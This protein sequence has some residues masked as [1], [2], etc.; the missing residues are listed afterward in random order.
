MGNPGPRIILA[1][2][3]PQRRSILS[4]L[5]IDFDVVSPDIDET[6]PEDLDTPDI[7]E[8]LARKKAFSV[9]AS[10]PSPA[11]GSSLVIA[12]DTL[13]LLGNRVYG[14]PADREEARRFL[15]DLGGKTH[16]V[17][18]GVAI[19]GPERNRIASCSESAYVTVDTINDLDAYL[20]TREWE[21]AAGAYRIQGRG[22]CFI[23]RVEGLESTVVGLP[24]HALWKMLNEYDGVPIL[25][26]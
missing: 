4:S 12:A 21:G 1:S 8:Y 13:V 6:P 18:T 7:P 17:V 26:R 20:D 3:S 24:I 25:K 14:K 10:L 15:W 22:A 9:A 23:S 5:G 2:A 11:R 16:R 19:A